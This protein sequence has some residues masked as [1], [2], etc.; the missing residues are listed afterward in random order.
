MSALLAIAAATATTMTAAQAGPAARGFVCGTAQ[1]AP[2]TNA[3]KADGGQVPVIRW[4][5]TTFETAGWSQERRCQEVSS[6]FNTYLQQGRLAY[7]TTGR[8][9][10]LPVICTARSNGGACDGLLYTL[11]PGQNATATLQNLLE[12]RVKARGPLNETTSRL[13]VSLDELMTTAQAN[14]S[15]MSSAAQPVSPTPSTKA[16]W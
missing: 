15:G 13:Y 4:T 3:V 12:I 5:S 6:R 10:G 2:S 9:N 16:L 14:A 8:I 7:I 1:G 11:K